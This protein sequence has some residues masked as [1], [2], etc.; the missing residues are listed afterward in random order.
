MVKLKNVSEDGRGNTADGQDVVS[1]G[2][3]TGW[4][5]GLSGEEGCEISLI[6]I[7]M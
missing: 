2:A 6:I 4:S 3:A 7:I 1:I 5:G